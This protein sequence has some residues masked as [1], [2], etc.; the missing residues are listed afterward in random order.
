MTTR[1]ARCRSPSSIGLKRSIAVPSIRAGSAA[2]QGQRL[3]CPGIPGHRVR[4]RDTPAEGAARRSGT[5]RRG[6]GP[7]APSRSASR[8]R[9]ASGGR[10]L[11]GRQRHRL[12]AAGAIRVLER[13]GLSGTSIAQI[14]AESGLSSGAIYANF[15]NKAELAREI[16]ASL[17][18]W[19]IDGIEET[20]AT[21]VVRT[22]VQVLRDLF[23]TME[24]DAA[25]I[26]LILQFWGRSTTDPELHEVLVATVTALRDAFERAVL[27]WAA[28]RG[29]DDAAALAHRTAITMVVLCQGFLAN[30]A[31][32]GWTTFDDHLA[33]A[34]VVFAG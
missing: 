17:L 12:A 19:R 33:G 26:P 34:A 28:S 22:P 15:E 18:R 30:A 11:G 24:R 6:R 4:R 10:E 21:G 20:T 3:R 32:L 1:F 14:V 2:P 29:E 8:G 5:H 25:P 7:V 31:L 27:P 23:A 9:P 13:T 16:A